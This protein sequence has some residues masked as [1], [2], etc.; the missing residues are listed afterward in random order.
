M[1][2]VRFAGLVAALLLSGCGAVATP[3]GNPGGEP[4]TSGPEELVGQGMVISPE[5]GP[6]MLCLGPVMES[7]PPQCSGPEII[8]WDWTAVDDSET[9]NGVTWGT[10]A[11]HGT[12]DGAAFTLTRP[13]IPLALYDPPAK[14]DPRTDP[15]NRGAGTDSELEALQ[16]DLYEAEGSSLLMSWVENGYLFI[17]VVYDDGTL[18][19]AYDAEYGSDTVAVQSALQ[20]V[21]A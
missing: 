8:G 13:P 12:W 1:V 19:D 21:D 7:Y 4:P 5:D 17:T 10:Y 9:S 3:G 20:P 11:V 15:A 14:I 16:Q 18:Q 2:R 6:A